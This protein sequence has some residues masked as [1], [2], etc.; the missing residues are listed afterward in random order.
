[1][2]AE[3][4]RREMGLSEGGIRGVRSALWQCAR[5]CFHAPSNGLHDLPGGCGCAVFP[6]ALQELSSAEGGERNNDGFASSAGRCLQRAPETEAPYLDLQQLMAFNQIEG[7]SIPDGRARPWWRAGP[8][9]PKD[10][11]CALPSGG[12][13]MDWYRAVRSVLWALVEPARFW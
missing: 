3:R 4:S 2:A 10:E 9:V 1:M 5:I 13:L 6:G 12:R 11:R 7:V 8:A